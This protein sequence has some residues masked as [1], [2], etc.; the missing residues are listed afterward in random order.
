MRII[1][2]LNRRQML[3][4]V[5]AGAAAFLLEQGGLQAQAPPAKTVVFSH[6]TVA[7]ANRALDDVAL[8]VTGNTIT[9]IGP[10]DDVLKAYPQAEVI[11]GRGKA[12]LPGLVNCHAH[13]SATIAR[14]FNEDFGFPNSMRLPIQPNSLLS[15]EESTLMAVVGALEAV[16]S[17][18]T[19]VVENTGN[20]GRNASQLAKTGQRW[21]FAESIRDSENASGA[22]SPEA[23][24][25]SE[26]PK[27]SAKQR[28]D[29]MRR[30]E[31]L[32]SA[33]HG[34]EGRISVFPAAGLAESSSPELLQAV[35]AFAEKHDLGYTIHLGQSHAEVNYMV[36][37]HGVRPAV[38]LAKSDFLGPRLF[39]GHCRYLDEQEI[40]LLG[41]SASIV[42]HQAP[43]AG[44]RGVLPPIAKLRAAGCTIANGTD[45]NTNDSFEV[46]RIALVTERIS[47][48]DDP[49]PG[50]YPQPEDMLQDATQ[51]GA[52]ATR[53]SKSLGTLEVGKKADMI[54]LNTRKIHLV[55]HMRIISAW[56]HNGQPSDI[57]S[58]M[59]DGKFVMRDGK[60]LTMDEEAI[61]AEAD[62][63]GRRVWSKVL[64]AGAVPIP[65][66]TG[67]K[68]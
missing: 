8:A 35:R 25:R 1:S 19:T 59:V 5:G 24:A 54:I 57:E 23:F 3:T 44:N 6:T 17:G 32:F 68:N 38:F 50:L 40:T 63:I 51:G 39:A 22:M 60:I 7:D 43:M 31:D 64:E 10:T 66:R 48:G 9:A 55:P 46:M 36:K 52:K 4:G 42:S 62:K 47:R 58:M 18:A 14:G 20:I 15:P 41:R 26:P 53:Q 12:L 33:W 56:I 49:T 21:V 29:G 67:L 61:V 37:Y 65:G 13:L 28:E 34:K 30:I 16:R 27:Y 11:D 45:N 2:S